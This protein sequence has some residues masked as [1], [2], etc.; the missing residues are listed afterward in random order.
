MWSDGSARRWRDRDGK[1]RVRPLKQILPIPSRLPRRREA[2]TGGGELPSP[3][4]D[5]GACVFDYTWRVGGCYHG[6][7]SWV[8]GHRMV[9][10]TTSSSFMHTHVYISIARQ[11]G[12][13]VASLRWRCAYPR[14]SSTQT[15]PLPLLTVKSPK[16]HP[17]L[18]AGVHI[19]GVLL[20]GELGWNAGGF[21]YMRA[22]NRS[23]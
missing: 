11:R 9:G 4:L 15:S 12:G 3:C 18:E 16:Q 20:C 2:S 19:G 7:R 5:A 1:C 10:I 21:A 13:A 6:K 17:R 23:C 14:K 22:Q 8:H